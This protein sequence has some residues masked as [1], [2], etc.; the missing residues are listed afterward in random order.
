MPQTDL[1][2]DEAIRQFFQEHPN[3]TRPSKCDK[4]ISEMFECSENAARS[5]R[6]RVYP[7]NTE[8]PWKA[9]E[10]KKEEA[11][12]GEA[13]TWFAGKEKAVP[14]YEEESE[15][16]RPRLVFADGYPKTELPHVCP[17][18]GVTATTLE[19]ADE[20]FGWRKVGEYDDGTPKYIVQSW[21][22][23]ARAE[24]AA[25]RRSSQNAA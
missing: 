4:R 8:R 6:Y 24:E 14:T 9:A 22:R 12:P 3:C 5:A 16:G 7:K 13:D 17:K 19:E 20:L 21:C 15:H 10:K 11:A 23:K 1:S 2:R 25:A 18:T